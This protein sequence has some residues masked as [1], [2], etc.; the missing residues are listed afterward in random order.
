[1][2]LKAIL[3]GIC[4]ACVL[5]M[6]AQTESFN[7]VTVGY[8]GLLPGGDLGKGMNTMSGFTVGYNHGFGLGAKP[9]FIEVGGNFNYNSS[10]G[11]SLLSLAIP[12]N[13]S[14]W[15]NVSDNISI[16]PYTGINFKINM[17]GSNDFFKAEGTKRF[18]MGWQ[19]GVGANISKFYVGLQYGI[20][21][22]PLQKADYGK[23]GSYSL[24]T[25][26]ITVNVGYNF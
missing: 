3:A 21:F 1:M 25:S 19:I 23:Y 12:V 6:S 22:L 24:N 13:Y 14:Y 15:F 17:Y 11:F 7:R 2:K 16:A 18:Q 8:S 10:N 20:D 9:M 4:L 5:P 26:S